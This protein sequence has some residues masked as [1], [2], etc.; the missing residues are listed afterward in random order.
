MNHYTLNEENKSKIRTY[1]PNM[2]EE[3]FDNIALNSSTPEEMTTHLELGNV[4]L[5]PENEKIVECDM[6]M[7]RYTESGSRWITS[8]KTE[9]IIYHNLLNKIRNK[10]E[11][12][13]ESSQSI[14]DSNDFIDATN[15]EKQHTMK[16]MLMALESL[17]DEKSK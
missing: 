15:E 5:W 3:D 8:R 6:P 14:F 7:Y 10:I 11:T 2:T 4:E 1:Y 17:I 9:Y 13:D 12:K 16:E